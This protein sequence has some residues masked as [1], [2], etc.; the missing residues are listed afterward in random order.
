M[1]ALSMQQPVAYL[2]GCLRGDAWLSSPQAHSQFG[3]LCLRC[4]DFDFA[5]TF[6][7]AI[8]AGF[9]VHA[10][11]RSDERGYA[12]VRK[13]NGGNRF[14]V[15]GGYEP[16][17]IEQKAAW[18]RGFFDSEG[19]ILLKPKP[20]HGPN[21]WDRRILMSGTN[22]RTLA[23]ARRLMRDINIESRVEETQPTASHIGKLPVFNLVVRG[24]REHL[25]RFAGSVG[26]SIVRKQTLFV[27]LAESYQADSSASCRAAQALGAAAK[28]HARAKRVPPLL[29]PLLDAMK[30]LNAMGIRPTYRRCMP[31]PNYYR[32]RAMYT[33]GE[34][35]KMIG[36]PS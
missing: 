10:H 9:G 20:S 18:L 22:L 30:E 26:S 28:R 17:G 23:M 25:L 12:L 2:A 24:G 6:A 15:L 34:L 32:V 3:Y 14:A 4:K 7:A 29:R 16:I 5:E 13:S 21:S 11:V 31:L 19:S 36:V 8:Y 35:L 33:H 27:R 1:K